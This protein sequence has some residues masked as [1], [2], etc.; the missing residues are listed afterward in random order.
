MVLTVDLIIKYSY[1][2]FSNLNFNLNLKNM[3]NTGLYKDSNT[4][5]LNY[6]QSFKH[7]SNDFKYSLGNS[8]MNTCLD[9]FKTIRYA[10]NDKNSNNKISHLKK[11]LNFCEEL[12]SLFSICYD[13]KLLNSTKYSDLF[14]ITDSIEKQSLYFLKTLEKHSE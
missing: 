12:K 9:I 11:C 8:I 4:L 5:L 3:K 6:C 10:L 13:L 1:N 14:K 2:N 7:F